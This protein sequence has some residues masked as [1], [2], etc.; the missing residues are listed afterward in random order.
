MAVMDW[1]MLDHLKDS[2]RSLGNAASLQAE[3]R[4]SRFCPLI[5][6]C[7]SIRSGMIPG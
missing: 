3:H 2:L 7:H 5:T 1:P 4:I 6:G